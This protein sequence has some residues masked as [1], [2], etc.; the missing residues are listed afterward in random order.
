MKRVS[1]LERF[2][3]E[4][5]KTLT[6]EGERVMSKTWAPDW[7]YTGIRHSPGSPLELPKV[8]R[9]YPRPDGRKREV[10][11]TFSS[12]EG[13]VYGA[14]HT[15][16]TIVEAHNPVWDG[17]CWCVFYNDRERART[18]SKQFSHRSSATR[19][20]K[21]VLLEQFPPSEYRYLWNY[22]GLKYEGGVWVYGNGD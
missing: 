12:W 10:S 21:K 22:R 9:M 16:V 11:V 19:W 5:G 17:D 1:L 8:V 13:Y 3:A 4:K 7:N 20:A 15:W 18:I 2:A 6:V 14:K